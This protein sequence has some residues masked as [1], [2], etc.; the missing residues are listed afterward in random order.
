MNY[1]LLLKIT[2][3]N[4]SFSSNYYVNIQYTGGI[5]VPVD[6]KLSKNSKIFRIKVIKSTF[7]ENPEH[8]VCLLYDT[9]IINFLLWYFI[10]CMKLCPVWF[11]LELWLVN[12]ICKQHNDPLDYAIISQNI[13]EYLTTHFPLNTQHNSFLR[14][15]WSS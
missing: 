12:D 9:Y 5:S 13:W 14:I 7:Y 15:I 2:Q 4:L 8:P 1:F 11:M 10:L 3:E 6:N